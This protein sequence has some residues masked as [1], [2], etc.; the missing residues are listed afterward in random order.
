MIVAMVVVVAM[1]FAFGN[2]IRGPLRGFIYIRFGGGGGGGGGGSR[3]G[4]CPSTSE[5]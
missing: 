5:C 2:G 4:I 1:G 3:N